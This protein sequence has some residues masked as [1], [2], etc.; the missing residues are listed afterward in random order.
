MVLRGWISPPSF[1][2]GTARAD[3]V[4]VDEWLMHT[5][6]QGSTAR[7]AEKWFTTHQCHQDTSSGPAPRIKL[8]AVLGLLY[9]FAVGIAASVVHQVVLVVYRRRSEGSCDA[10]QALPVGAVPAT[11]P[12]VKLDEPKMQPCIFRVEVTTP[13]LVS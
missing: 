6:Y 1:N 10:K 13:T 12:S 2:T 4:C 7:A 11:L 8:D 5:T 3:K 9:I